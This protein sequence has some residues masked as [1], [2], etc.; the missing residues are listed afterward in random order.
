[1]LKCRL[2]YNYISTYYPILD[3]M[4]I[5]AI[6]VDDTCNTLSVRQ[7]GGSAILI[8][9]HFRPFCELYYMTIRAGCRYNL[10]DWVKFQQL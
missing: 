10:S 6:L 3:G 7:Y 5:S 9:K 4:D 2:S 1:M 8:R